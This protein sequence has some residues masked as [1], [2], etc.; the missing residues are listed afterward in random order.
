MKCVSVGCATNK[1][2]TR[3]MDIQFGDGIRDTSNFTDRL[4]LV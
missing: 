3:L 4:K 2:E 1:K